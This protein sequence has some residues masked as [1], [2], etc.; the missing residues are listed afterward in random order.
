MLDELGKTWDTPRVG[1]TL[2]WRKLF[3][4]GHQAGG[5]PVLAVSGT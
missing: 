1:P 2:A 3:L 5:N 4:R